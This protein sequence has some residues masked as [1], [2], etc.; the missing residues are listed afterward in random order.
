MPFPTENDYNIYNDSSLRMANG[1]QAPSDLNIITTVMN[2]MTEDTGCKGM[3]LWLWMGS[4]ENLSSDEVTDTDMASMS[5]LMCVLEHLQEESQ[6][7][8]IKLLNLPMKAL[9]RW[10]KVVAEVHEE[11]G[12]DVPTPGQLERMFEMGE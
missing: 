6:T 12:K 9:K 10:H 1:V 11:V 3:A 8:I 4:K 2:Q 5:V 7:D